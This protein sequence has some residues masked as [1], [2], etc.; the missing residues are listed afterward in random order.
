VIARA[1]LVTAFAAL[2]VLPPVGQRFIVTG[3]EARFAVLAQDMLARGTWFDARVRD[4]RYRNKPLLY[5]WTIKLLS[6]PGGRVTETTAL[7]PIAVAAVA[8]VFLVTLLGQQLFSP[9]AGIAAGLVTATSYGF[10]AHSQIFLP[11]MLV[12]AFGLAA[13]CAFWASVT[14]PPGTRALAG[15]WAAVALGV[16]A[17]G[18]MGLLPVLVVIVWLLTEE[19][20][21]GLRRLVSRLGAIA[22]AVV[23]LAWLVPYL[24][25]GSRSFARSVLWED[26]LGWY[27]GGPPPLKML[28]MLLDGAK[29]FI[30]WTTVLVLPLL[31]V[32]RQWRDA[33]YRFAFLAWLLPLVSVLLSQNHRARYLL[34]VYPAGALL[35]AWWSQQALVRS[36][37]VVVTTALTAL[38][39][40]V[41]LVVFALPWTDPLERELVDR[42]WS[43]AVLLVAGGV[44]VTAWACLTLWRAR[45]RALVVGVALATGILL[46]VGVQFHNRWVNRGQDHPALAAL[47]ER[48]AQGGDVGVLGGRFFSI[49]FYLGRALT[50][51]RTV[52]AFDTWVGR[53]DRPL[54][55]ITGRAW[56]LLR[57]QAR[58]DVEVVDTMRVRK[59][60][61]FLLRRAD[62]PVTR[63][64]ATPAAAQPGK[65]PGPGAAPP[66]PGAP[67]PAAPR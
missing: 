10:F 55:V 5:P 19:G 34:P 49:D 54:V 6:M 16:A 9:W 7:L 42:F 21:R 50:P 27:L 24:F 39:G 66:R 18:P 64:G 29:G 46:A 25:A 53:P 65:P 57:A 23:T 63:A 20:P 17:K 37:A 43:K 41:A 28:N 22:F 12:V 56:S 3:D 60:L 44:A 52:E 15:F 48:Y 2:L 51:V 40:L 59:H 31:A 1:A 11:D 13:L 58:P 45:P 4:Q 35:V 67:A 8:S 26:W 33:P 62:P 36:R 32:R 47:V 38:G 30:P 61:M 14:H